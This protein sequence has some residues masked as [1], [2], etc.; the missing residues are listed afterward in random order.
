MKKVII[1]LSIIAAGGIGISIYKHREHVEEVRKIK[2][3]LLYIDQNHVLQQI[4][5]TRQEAIEFKHIYLRSGMQQALDRAN[6]C[7][8]END[9]LFKELDRIDHEISKL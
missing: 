7:Y 6:E 8:R 3:D 2:L 9:S 1:T 4:G 5:N